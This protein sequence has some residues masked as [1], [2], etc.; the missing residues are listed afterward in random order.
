MC[1]SLSLQSLLLPS[2]P[3]VIGRVI[4]WRLYLLHCFSFHASLLYERRVCVFLD[5]MEGNRRRLHA[6]YRMGSSSLAA[7]CRLCVFR[8]R[9]RYILPPTSFVKLANRSPRP[10]P[11]PCSHSRHQ[12]K[13]AWRVDMSMRVA[14]KYKHGQLGIRQPAVTN[15]RLYDPLRR[16][17]VVTKLC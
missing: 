15:L 16:S 11:G 9:G 6:H 17:P 3:A 10:P 5:I 8:L 7:C 4:D 14:A 2:H 12:A 1:F 13:E